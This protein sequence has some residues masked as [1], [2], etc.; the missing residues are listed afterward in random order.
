MQ[1]QFGPG[2]L[3]GAAEAGVGW[4]EDHLDTIRR[5]RMPPGDAA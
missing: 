3:A 1:T 4:C 5:S 2:A